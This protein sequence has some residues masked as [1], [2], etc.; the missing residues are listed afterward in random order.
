[1]QMFKA[2][3]LHQMTILVLVL[4]ALFNNVSLS[5]IYADNTPSRSQQQD[6]LDTLT[7]SHSIVLEPWMNNKAFGDGADFDGSG[8]FFSGQTLQEPSLFTGYSI[9]N[10][11]VEGFDNIKC[12]DEKVIPLQQASLG[13]LY[14]FVSTTHGPLTAKITVKYTDETQD[15]T[16]LSLP[17]WQDPL[18]DQ[19]E[20]YYVIQQSL[21]NGNKGFMFNVPIYINPIKKPAQLFLLDGHNVTSEA[22][23]HVFSLIGY[24]KQQNCLAIVSIEATHEWVNVNEQIIIIR[25]H[26][27]GTDVVR[28]T[29]LYVSHGPSKVETIKAGLIEAI[30]PG[31]THMA[32][33]VV[34]HMSRSE[35]KQKK[36]A[37]QVLITAQYI[38]QTGKPIHSLTKADVLFQS[39]PLL[40]KRTPASVQKHRPPTWLKQAKFGI[41]IHWGL[42]SVPA[43]APV[44][45]SYAEWYWWRVNHQADPAYVY[46]R[47]TFGEDFGYDQFLNQWK[48]THFD[49]GTWLDL[50]DQSRAKYY[51][52]T[53]KHHDGI[54]LFNTNVTD[55][56]TA[57]LLQPNRD[58][59]G[60]LMRISETSYPHLKRGLY[61]EYS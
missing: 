50:I 37:T 29:R 6:E 28:N 55:R 31:H 32:R 24:P 1:M 12:N 8:T 17:D 3:S 57:K 56:S 49:P 2:N 25:V 19:L 26:N 36:E 13:A 20:R 14:A 11:I 43:W 51:V 18:A 58:F 4:F 22:A 35:I 45:K 27:I 54:A 7:E 48:P 30:A 52:F 38:G 53:T 39:S 60:D 33:V 5:H 47:N 42:Y 44:G 34:K 21:S 16:M 9:N 40:Y 61:C 15:S 46:H 41:F 59:V 10:S 23:L